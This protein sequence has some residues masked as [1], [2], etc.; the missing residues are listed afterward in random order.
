MPEL[1]PRFTQDTRLLRLST[2][3]GPECLLAESLRGEESL[4]R[5]Y[6]LQVSALSLDAAIPLKSLLG[7]PVLL[8]VLTA[9]PGM[10]LRPFHGHI[11]SAQL[12]GANGGFA[13]YGLT[14]EPWFAFLALGRDSRI[15]QDKTVFDILDA[16]FQ[17]W[18]DRGTLVPAW[19]CDIADRDSYQVRSLTCQYQES[20]L[21]FVQRLMHEEGLFYYVEY[22]AAPDSVQLG[23]HTSSSPTTTAVSRR[24]RRPTSASRNPARNARGQRRPLVDAVAPGPG[25]D[26]HSELGLPQPRIA[27]GQR[28]QR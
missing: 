7:Q 5:P 12:I 17:A 3:L 26:R 18:P 19:R 27:P 11:T 20:N 8:E 2:P 21:A 14:I 23:S 22:S 6:R 24:I 25:H 10:P 16:V 9:V 15:F 1:F 28:R 13:R 4:D